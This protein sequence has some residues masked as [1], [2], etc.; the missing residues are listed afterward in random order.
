MA[1][2]GIV[3][4][5]GRRPLFA[6]VQRRKD[7]F[8]VLPKGKLKRGEKPAAAAKREAAEETG[9]NVRQHEFLGTITSE[10]GGKQKI[11]HFW[12]MQVTNGADRRLAS[13]IKAVEWLPLASAV[14][15]LTQPVERTFLDHI[16]SRALMLSRAADDVDTKSEKRERAGRR[17]GSSPARK[18]LR[19]SDAKTARRDGRHPSHNAAA[20]KNETAQS[21]APSQAAPAEHAKKNI[22][23]R[24]LGRLRQNAALT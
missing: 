17:S 11:V 5:G 9:Q 15:R 16:G 22:L 10:V 4:R 23:R 1:A 12:R 21:A 18:A 19:R 20:R 3:I 6:V 13:D 14:G 8:W 2:G 7:N 24:F